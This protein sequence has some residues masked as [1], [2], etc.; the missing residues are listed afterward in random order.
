MAHS[1]D[2]WLIGIFCYLGLNGWFRGGF[3]IQAMKTRVSPGKTISQLQLPGT[4]GPLPGKGLR[5]AWEKEDDME[6]AQ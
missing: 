2:S 1:G 6:A 3:V 5:R 4:M